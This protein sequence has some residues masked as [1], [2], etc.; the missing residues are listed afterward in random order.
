MVH[1]TYFTMDLSFSPSEE[2]LVGGTSHNYIHLWNVQTGELITTLEGH[3][4]DVNSVV[5]SP[6][7][8][9]IVSGSRDGTVRLWGMPPPN[10]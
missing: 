5:F 9:A 10:N 1:T 7:G 8:E 2:I 3:N 6:D 4:A